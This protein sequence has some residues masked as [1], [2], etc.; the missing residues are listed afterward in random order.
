VKKFIVITATLVCAL[1]FLSLP[2]L[3]SENKE[4]KP[5]AEEKPSLIGD[6][7]MVSSVNLDG[8]E[9]H[10]SD[11]GKYVKKMN[12]KDKTAASIS[13][14]YITDMSKTPYTVDLCIGKCGAPGSEWTTQFCIFR[15]PSPDSLEIR[16]SPDSKH[17]TEFAKPDDKQTEFYIRKKAEPEKEKK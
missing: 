6:W 5:E 13:G 16:I 10:F 17:P 3:T 1:I 8:G 2:A 7:I 15:F 9:L 11:D 12:Y 14:P 4:A